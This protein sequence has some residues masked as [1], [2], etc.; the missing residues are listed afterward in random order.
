MY[1]ELFKAE[2]AI[3]TVLGIQ[4]EYNKKTNEDKKQNL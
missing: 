2:L 3:N 1:Q 4:K